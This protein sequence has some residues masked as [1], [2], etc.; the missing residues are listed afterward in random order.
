YALEMEAKLDQLRSLVEAADRD[1]V[2]LLNQL[3]EEKRKVEDLQFRVEEA[4]ITKGDLET[5]TRLEHAHIK[6][7]EQSLLFEKTKAEKLQRDLEDTRVATVSERS[8][9]M[10]LEREVADLQLRLRASQQ[11][12]D[13]VSLSQQQI[14]SLK[15]KVQSQEKKI[16]ELSVD[17]ERKQ[18]ELQ[19]VLQERTSLE[20]QLSSL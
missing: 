5:Q 3:E 1:K 12:E 2:E 6:E 13:A 16:S 15:A 20:Q 11:K 18:K 19:S 14:S 7:L 8:R 4:C 17:L 9:I 10:E